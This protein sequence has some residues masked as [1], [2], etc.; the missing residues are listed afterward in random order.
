MVHCLVWK[1]CCGQN[2]TETLGFK[3]QEHAQEPSKTQ[4]HTQEPTNT[5]P[6]APDLT[7]AYSVPCPVLPRLLVTLLTLLGGGRGHCS[8]EGGRPQPGFLLQKWKPLCLPHLFG[9]GQW[10]CPHSGVCSAGRRPAHR[11]E[12]FSKDMGAWYARTGWRCHLT[13][14]P[15]LPGFSS[16][17]LF[18]FLMVMEL[19]T[20]CF[21][22]KVENPRH[23]QTAHTWGQ[24]HT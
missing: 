13:A 15:V 22:T 9:N 1:S 17:G 12:C 8:A 23:S 16:L 20:P 24:M 21:L 14:S 7:G 3:T 5:Q 18:L 2:L 19:V 11:M 4:E 10:Q 6:H